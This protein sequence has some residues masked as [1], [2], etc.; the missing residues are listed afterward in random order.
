MSTLRLPVRNR[1][2]G[3][4]GT[5]LGYPIYGT[6]G[7]EP[8]VTWQAG[9]R[10][11]IVGTDPRTGKW[12]PQHLDALAASTRNS[13]AYY[14]DRDGIYKKVDPYVQRVEWNGTH[15]ERLY[16]AEATNYLVRSY[17]FSHA[18]WEKH[19]SAVTTVGSPATAIEGFQPYGLV[20]AAVHTIHVLIYGNNYY[21]GE[22][23][24][25]LTVSA[26]VK[27]GCSDWV[28]LY[29]R[30]HD[31]ATP[32]TLRWANFNLT[33]EAVG[34]TLDVDRTEIKALGDGWYRISLSVDAKTTTSLYR[35][36]IYAL[37]GDAETPAVIHAG[38]TGDDTTVNFWINHF[39]VS[40]TSWTP[41]PIPTNGATAT[42]LA[43][44]ERILR[45]H[46]PALTAALSAG[47]QFTA[48]AHCTFGQANT[49]FP[50]AD[51]GLIAVRDAESSLLYHSAANT[52]DFSTHDGTT[53]AAVAPAYLANARLRAIVKG[54]YDD[55]GLKMRAGYVDSTG[56]LTWGVEQAYDGG[57]T[58]GDYL[59]AFFGGFGATRANFAIYDRVI[60]DAEIT[61]WG[62]P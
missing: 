60:P 30:E 41:N 26:T 24:T 25:P 6:V 13:D 9:S 59:N 18:D 33:T 40:N 38:F 39:Q 21:V 17:D 42:K 22:A 61:S 45:A 46:L 49:V 37:P 3:Y 36:R 47:G 51:K 20:A 2:G 27:S 15:W 55:G 7:G 4:R 53:Q 19:N 32:S 62:T 58:L 5:L 8:K 34:H 50:A 1:S 23:G 52:G 57:Y 16:E 31:G 56:N 48:V 43:D 12:F 10:A 11:P 54:G 14:L 28:M 29:V 35:T 44:L